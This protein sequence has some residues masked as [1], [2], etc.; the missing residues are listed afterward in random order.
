MTPASAWRITSVAIPTAF[1]VS[2][3]TVGECAP[4]DKY[5][6]RLTNVGGERSKGPIKVTDTLPAGVTTSERRQG[7]N[8]EEWNCVPEQEE[9]KSLVECTLPEPHVVGALKQAP[10]LTVYVKVEP[11]VPTGSVGPNV[12]KVEGGS[13]AT[14]EEATPTLLNPSASLPFGLADFS[15]Y[16]ADETGLPDSQAAD[17]SNSLTTSFD[18]TS[19]VNLATGGRVEPTRPSEDVKDIV[20]DLPTGFVGDPQAAQ[21]CS[22]HDL[23]LF[24]TGSGCPPA[25]QV[26]VVSFDGDGSYQGEVFQ[27]GRQNVPI[28]NMVPEHGYPAEFGFLF[29]EKPLLMYASVVGNG[30]AAHVRVSV[31]GIPASQLLGLQGAVV[32]FFG[33]PTTQD[34]LPGTPVA[35]FTNPSACSGEPLI[36]SIHV[37]SWQN[38]GARESN[39]TPDFSESAGSAWK[40]DKAQTPAVDGCGALHFNPTMSLTPDLAQAGAPTGLGVNLDVPQSNDPSIPATPD[41]KQ[42]VVTL[43]PGMVVSPSAANG[44]AACSPVQI[45]LDNNDTPSCP[46]SS[47]IATV[48]V[49][50]PLLAEELEGSVYLA[51]QGNAGPAQ[52]SNPFNSLLAIYIVVEGSGVV[53]KLPGKV[54]ANE[55]TGQLTTSFLENPQLPF[56]DFKLHFRGGA[57]APLSNPPACGTYTPQATLS[58]WSGQTV[59]SNRSFEITQGENSAACPG[60]VFTPSFTAGTTNNQAGAYSPLVVH[61]NREDDS[62]NFSQ[63]SVTLPPGATGKLAG[64]PQCSDA[65][66]ATAQSRSHPGEGAAELANPS[67]PAS[68]AIGTVT[69]GAG[70]G[71]DPFY[72]TGKAYLAGPYKGAPFSGVFITPAIAGPFDLGAVVVRAGLYINPTTAQV[73]TKADPLPSILDGI[74]LDIRSVTV[75][76]DRPQFTLNPTNCTPMSVTGTITST[77]GATANVSNTFDAANCAMLPFHPNFTASTSAKTSKANG[78][79]LNVNI[80]S[81]GIGQADIAKVDLAIPKILPSRLTTLN[82]ACTEVVFNANPAT[83]PSASD[84]ATAIVRTPLLSGPLT[85]PAYLVSHGGAAFPDVEIILQGEGITLVLDGKTQI[86]GGVTFSHFETVPDQ[87]FNTF[88][89]HGPEGPYSIFTATGN[90]CKPTKMITVKER[91]T[92]RARGRLEHLTVKVKKAVPE[93]L[94]MPTTMTGQNGAQLK[95][96]TKIAVT[97]CPKPKQAKNHK[98]ITKKKGRK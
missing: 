35:F 29:A 13:A 24:S 19:A 47:K 44:L 65:Q 96:N 69:V 34:G 52:G 56:S 60:N 49:K 23:V 39:G 45:Q 15:S 8:E 11:G 84:I 77:L 54:E 66:I 75:N 51:Q 63:I 53:I 26:G 64:I 50:T 88:E 62:Q 4:C 87:P 61:L 40:L 10:T 79:T 78:A 83:C 85:G 22:L 5:Q 32:T 97:G 73:T 41:L 18:V 98:K 38:Q 31:P 90:L 86:K 92:R 59:Q 74:P 71:E 81:A 12:V 48:R 43:P 93:T 3:T 36:T 27:G 25:S 68:S 91:V 57:G 7:N 33:D 82:K 14:V 9:G 70:P 46:K 20:V 55:Q 95:Q 72:V 30:A 1:S 42:V 28:Y 21:Q 16:L 58:A 76:V 37:D 80:A 67:C 17:H 6:L 2:D 89:F 94:V